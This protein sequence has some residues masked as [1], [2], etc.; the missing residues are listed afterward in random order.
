MLFLFAIILQHERH[1]RLIGLYER[2]ADAVA[3]A[4]R[5]PASRITIEACRVNEQNL[6]L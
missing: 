2:L 5:F 3:A 1:S 4:Q 6:L